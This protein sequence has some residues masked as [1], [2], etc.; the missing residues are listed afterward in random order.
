VPVLND[1]AIPSMTAMAAQ[2]KLHRQDVATVTGGKVLASG[3]VDDPYLDKVEM[4]EHR[5]ERLMVPGVDG[6]STRILFFL[7]EGDGEVTVHFDSLKGGQL[8]RK[9]ALRETVEAKPAM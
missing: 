9:V 2:N 6:L 1:R 3:L 7:I 5:A 8:A 4:Q